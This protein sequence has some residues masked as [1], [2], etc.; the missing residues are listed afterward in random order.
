MSRELT[1]FKI[2]WHSHFK[3]RLIAKKVVHLYNSMNFKEC[4]FVVSAVPTK[5]EWPS[6]VKCWDTC[7]NSS[8]KSSGTF[9]ANGVHSTGLKLENYYF[10][11]FTFSRPEVRKLLLFYVFTFSRP[12]VRKLLL[13]Y[14]FT[15]SRPEVRKLLLFYVFTFS[16]PEVRKSLLF[17]VFTFSRPEVRKLLLFYVFTF[18]RP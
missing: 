8:G 10:F 12:E 9:N 3:W 13:F 5:S 14:V 18:S 16:R 1:N 15:F 17:Y 11:T 4:N 7:R 2:G 6:T